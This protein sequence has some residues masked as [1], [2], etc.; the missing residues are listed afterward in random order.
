MAKVISLQQRR[1][2]Q[3]LEQLNRLTGLD[4]Q[5]PPESLLGNGAGRTAKHQWQPRARRG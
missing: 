4:F 1:P 5:R 3:A 2:Q